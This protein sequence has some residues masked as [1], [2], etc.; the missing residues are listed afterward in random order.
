MDGVLAFVGHGLAAY[1]LDMRL[2]DRSPEPPHQL[3]RRHAR[4][5]LDLDLVDLPGWP[6]TLAA[7]LGVN[8]LML[9]PRGLSALPHLTTP[10]MT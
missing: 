5:A 9:A 10:V 6:S 7:V 8:A 3:G 4:S 2:V 1:D